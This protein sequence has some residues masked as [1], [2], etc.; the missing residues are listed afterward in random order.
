MLTIKRHDTLPD[1]SITCTDNG[2]VVDLS[3]ATGIKVIGTINAIPLFSRTA[4]GNTQGVVTMGWQAADTANVGIL[5]IEVEV[6]WPAGGGVQTFP[7]GGY[8]RVNVERDL[9]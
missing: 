7:G 9:G 6:T 4:T 1:L 3:T 2:A 5:D 8:L